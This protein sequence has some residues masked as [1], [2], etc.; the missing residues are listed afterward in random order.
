MIGRLHKLQPVLYLC[1]EST[2]G[3]SLTN[4]GFEPDRIGE[5]ARASQPNYDP[6][7]SF[8]SRGTHFPSGSSPSEGG[9]SPIVTRSTNSKKKPHP[10]GRGRG[11]IQMK[12][13]RESAIR[14]TTTTM[15][16][17]LIV[18]DPLSPRFDFSTLARGESAPETGSGGERSRTAI[19]SRIQAIISRHQDRP[20]PLRQSRV[21][22]WRPGPDSNWRWSI[23]GELPCRLGY[24]APNSVHET[25]I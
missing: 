13:A 3:S 8:A 17:A 18:N 21:F 15:S 1:I 10:C 20:V 4:V 5:R 14:T 24:P 12:I 19:P 22:S 9:V 6:G 2:V 11:H 25:H 23:S 16:I 7:S